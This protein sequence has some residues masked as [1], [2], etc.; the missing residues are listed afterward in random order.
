MTNN[1]LLCVYREIQRL[2]RSYKVGFGAKNLFEMAKNDIVNIGQII[3][4]F[5]VKLNR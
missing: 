1:A 2:S 4:H 3:I 5:I